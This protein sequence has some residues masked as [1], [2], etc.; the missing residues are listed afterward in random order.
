VPWFW[1]LPACATLGAVV[2]FA[3]VMRRVGDEA[4]ALRSSLVD[5]NRLTVAIADLEHE[6]RHAER[7]IRRLTSRG[8]SG[9]PA[10]PAAPGHVAG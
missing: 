4:R 3:S 2:V 10:D 6:G 1:L 9:L 8:R 7:D 5:W